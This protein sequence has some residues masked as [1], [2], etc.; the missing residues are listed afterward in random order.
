MLNRRDLLASG[1]ASLAVAAL[2]ANAAEAP[3]AT[4]T[5]DAIADRFCRAYPAD[6]TEL[7]VDSGTRAE[8]R[9]KLP[10]RSVAGQR[11]VAA[12]LRQDLAALDRLDP[13]TLDATTKVHVDVVRTSYTTAL[14]G[15]AFPYGEVA[16]GSWR[17]SP[18]PVIQNVGAYIDVPR[19][20]TVTQKLENEADA[21]Y[22]LQRLA[23]FAA[24]LD[25]ETERVRLGTA[26][27]AVPPDFLLDKALAQLTTVRAGDPAAWEMVTRLATKYPAHGAEAARIAGER[28]L[29][30]FGRQIAALRDQRTRAGSD[31]GVWRLP[32]GD[33]YYRW[34]LR[35]ATTTTRSPDELHAQGLDELARYQA[36]MDVIL[37]PLGYT[38]GSVG[39]RMTALGKDPRFLFP[40]NDTGRAQI[41][42]FLQA[43]IDAIRPKLATAF[44]H[45]VRGRVEVRRI[46]IAEEPGAAG[47]YG[48]SGAIDGST[49][50]RLWINLRN[51]GGL[52]RYSL[53]TLA[54]H[55]AIPG[56]AWQGEYAFR[57]PLIRN[58][59]SFSAY[60]EGWALYA[61]QLADE[62]GMY[63]DDPV[64]RL[65]FLQS[66]AFRACRLVVDTGL[67]AKRWSRAKAVQW[68]ADANGQD[69][70]EVGSEVDRYCSWPG[71]ACAYKVGHSEILRLRETAK[72]RLDLKAFDDRVVGAGPVP[73]TVLGRIVAA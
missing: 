44:A 56:H 38:Q 39:A 62:L 31:A 71:Q 72:G 19:L 2:P 50:G 33:A 10:D 57:L 32:H 26:A 69:P 49:P 24:E 43:Q 52:P 47:A 51:P 23:G 55:E 9:G 35:S 30:A 21:G 15:F 6:A 58:L 70:V 14:E 8:L 64:N 25:G 37:R 68:F 60:Q 27:G 1:T 18:Y 11:A 36:Q 13:A 48:G 28:V 40:D 65:G 12:G 5:L 63:A 67:H 3:R 7:G 20:L 16:T 54:Y 42:A 29:P 73:M 66:M 41:I 4:S 61:E 46:P 53:P 22:Y 59:L 17:N 34:A 45:P